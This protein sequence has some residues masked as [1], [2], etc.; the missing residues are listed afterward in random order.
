GHSGAAASAPG[1]IYCSRRR[2]RFPPRRRRFFATPL[3]RAPAAARARPSAANRRAPAARAE[4]RRCRGLR[5][6]TIPRACPPARLVLRKPRAPAREK[7]APRRR[8]AHARSTPPGAPNRAGRHTPAKAPGMSRRE[9]KPKSAR[10]TGLSSISPLQPR[11]TGAARV[12]AP[13]QS[14]FGQSGG[15]FQSQTRPPLAPGLLAPQVALI[16]P[17]HHRAQARAQTLE[18]ARDLADLVGALERQRHGE[19]AFA[20]LLG[21]AH[22]I[23]EGPINRARNGD[24]GRRRGDQRERGQRRDR[25]EGAARLRRDEAAPQ[26]QMDEAAAG[27]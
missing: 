5:K 19:F 26:A 13:R 3:P 21:V 16:Q 4:A 14:D 6:K 2:R 11:R 20:D 17:A 22:Q 24:E 27:V 25:R 9:E 18:G 10:R 1:S 23:G 15:K 12:P 7:S 8:P